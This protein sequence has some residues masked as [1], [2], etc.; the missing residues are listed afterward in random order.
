MALARSSEIGA[1]HHFHHFRSP[2]T[3]PPIDELGGTEAP[4]A[5]ER[6]PARA[7]AGKRDRAGAA[8]LLR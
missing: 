8:P 6:E 4:N 3:F 1:C 2:G 7:T 5:I